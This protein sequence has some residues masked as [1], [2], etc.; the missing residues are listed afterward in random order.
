MLQCT[1]YNN[2]IKQVVSPI[3]L[4]VEGAAGMNELK[5][6][7]CNNCDTIKSYGHENNFTSIYST[8]NKNIK[9]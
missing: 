9:I 1:Q 3:R 6:G 4:T 8:L 7:S 5:C 2:N